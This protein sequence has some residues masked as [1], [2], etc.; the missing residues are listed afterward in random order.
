MLRFPLGVTRVDRI[1]TKQ[2]RGTVTVEQLGHQVIETLRMRWFGR[3]LRR[4]GYFWIKD[5]RDGVDRQEERRKTSGKI[6]MEMVGVKAE[7]TE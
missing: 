1:K 5:V 2:I 3:V 6:D 7:E 4:D